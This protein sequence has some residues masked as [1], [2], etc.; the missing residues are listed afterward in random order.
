VSG[1]NEMLNVFI[2]LIAT[3]AFMYGMFVKRKVIMIIAAL[4]VIG[5]ITFLL[6][7]IPYI[8]AKVAINKINTFNISFP[9]LT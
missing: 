5:I 9:P 7:N 6:T 2:L 4:L 1:G 3:L 8:N